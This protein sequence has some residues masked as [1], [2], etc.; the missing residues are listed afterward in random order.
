MEHRRRH[1]QISH[2]HESSSFHKKRNPHR[3]FCLRSFGFLAS[4]TFTAKY[5]LW[6]MNCGWDDTIP[7]AHQQWLSGLQQ[8]E[9]YKTVSNQRTL[10]RL[11]LFN[12]TNF[13]DTSETG[14]GFVELTSAIL[15]VKV[16]RMLKAELQVPL[17]LDRQHFRLQIH[18]N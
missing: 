10:E 16:E 3:V 11:H 9:S 12:F 15:A 17:L 2:N 4:F 1:L 6:K 14:Y 7:G 5:E 13:C 18:K 8:M